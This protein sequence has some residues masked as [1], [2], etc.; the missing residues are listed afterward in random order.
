MLGSILVLAQA[1]VSV[2]LFKKIRNLRKKEK[3]N[4]TEKSQDIKLK[5]DGIIAEAKL[6]AGVNED[7]KV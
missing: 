4:Y 3:Q 5:I 1:V 6:L 2:Y 7:E